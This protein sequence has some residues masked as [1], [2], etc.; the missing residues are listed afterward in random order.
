MTLLA[1]GP[2]GPNEREA[3][4][5]GGRV[6][7]LFRGPGGWALAFRFGRAAVPWSREA[8]RPCPSF[9]HPLRE[10]AST[11][12]GRRIVGAGASAVRDDAALD[13]PSASLPSR[14][15]EGTP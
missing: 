8:E 6:R 13:V 5:P 11:S 10:A 14:T 4:G 7:V 9:R 15:C 3:T 1:A 12:S 2:M